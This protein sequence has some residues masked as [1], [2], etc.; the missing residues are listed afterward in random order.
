MIISAGYNIAGP[1][2]ERHTTAYG[3]LAAWLV[4]VLNTLTGNLDRPG[5]AMFPTPRTR[6]SGGPHGSS[7][8]AAGTAASAA[9]RR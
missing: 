4:D 6:G 5:G 9:W 3:T 2:D 7:G 8:P 1:M